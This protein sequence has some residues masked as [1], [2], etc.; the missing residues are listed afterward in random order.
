[1]CLFFLHLSLKQFIFYEALGETWSQMYVGIRVKWLLILSDFSETWIFSTDF[2][3]ILKYQISWKSVQWGP[4]CSM[5]T[6]GQT[7]RSWQSLFAIL[8]TRLKNDQSFRLRQLSV[9]M[10]WKYNMAEQDISTQPHFVVEH[11]WNVMAHPQKPD[12]VFRRNGRVHLNRP[13]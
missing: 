3:K 13:Q 9:L 4:S 1:M 10:R 7:W 6:E 11:V 5:R 8:R 2:R 12:F